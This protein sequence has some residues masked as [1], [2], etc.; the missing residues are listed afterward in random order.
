[1]KDIVE[2][3]I[4]EQK[5]KTVSLITLEKNL[6]ELLKGNISPWFYKEL[7]NGI[8]ELE[9]EGLIEP[10]KS[11]KLYSRDSRIKEK[12]KK[13]KISIENEKELK[14][15]L[16]MGFH[17]RISVMYYL[18]HLEE[19]QGVKDKVKAISGFFKQGTEYSPYLSVNERSYELFG[20]EKYLASEDGRKVLA[21]LRLSLE[22][23]CC[24]ET[25]E[26]F[27]HIGFVQK[28][29]ESILI[30][31]NKDSF[32]SMKKLFLK[33]IRSWS[34]IEFSMIVYGEGNKITKSFEYLDE[35]EVPFDVNIYY[36]GDFDPEGIAIYHRLMK[37]NQRSV[38]IMKPFYEK[39][40]EN[41]KNKTG[42]KQYWNKEAIGKFFEINHFLEE[43][44]MKEYLAAGKYVPQEAVHIEMLRRM[45]DGVKQA[46]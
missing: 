20:E 19:Y 46:L 44:K 30:I 11:A 17:H 2:R 35:L 39:M 22:D 33:N 40:F 8:L 4:K 36:F 3:L 31:E 27:F 6:K 12:Y 43:V 7:A 21:K 32:F 25:F 14:Q 23:L 18:D 24:F 41:R 29:N 10:F 26:Q 13:K 15:E 28:E 38:Q 37:I 1:M 16:L 45:A 9:K 42:N 5:T 34:G